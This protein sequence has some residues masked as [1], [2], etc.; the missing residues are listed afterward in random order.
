[1]TNIKISVIVPVYNAEKYLCRCVDSILA[2]TFQN[3]ELLLIDDGSYDSSARICDDYVSKDSRIKVYHKKNGGV[4]SARNLG[5]ANAQGEWICFVD[6][7]DWLDKDFLEGFDCN[8]SSDLLIQGCKKH[9]GEKTINVVLDVE[10]FTGVNM[11]RKIVDFEKRELLIFRP[12]WAKLFKKKVIEDN[13]LSFDSKIQIGEDFLFVLYYILHINKMSIS[14]NCGYNYRIVEG[15]LTF[16]PYSMATRIN[17]SK[18]FEKIGSL[19]AEKYK[20]PMILEELMRYRVLGCLRN[21]YRKECKQEER[22]M[23][24]QYYHENQANYGLKWLPMPYCLISCLNGM[25]ETLQDK[26]LYF[27]FSILNKLKTFNISPQK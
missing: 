5:I 25:S 27:V 11:L 17:I 1:M 7:D 13:C 14:S 3:F 22:L 9:L 8:K 20:Y 21:S 2:Q 18:E 23:A 6:S 12:P 4:S 24:L 16:K 19:L 10:E 15:S 26:L